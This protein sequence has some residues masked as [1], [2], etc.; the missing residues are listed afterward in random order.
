M[1]SIMNRFRNFARQTKLAQDERGLTT[2]EYV[3]V[4][5]L[6]AA[7]S[8]GTWNVLGGN[9]KKKLGDAQ[10]EINSKVDQGVKGQ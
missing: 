8:V 9:I 6:I 3:I 5:V 2:V 10:G 7:A 4:L 1:T